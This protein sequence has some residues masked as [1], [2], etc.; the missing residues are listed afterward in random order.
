M[1]WLENEMRI[2]HDSKLLWVRC[3]AGNLNKM[4]EVGV[5]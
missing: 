5:D 3:F 1:R 2:P 4:L